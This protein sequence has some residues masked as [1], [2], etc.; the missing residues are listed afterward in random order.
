MTDLTAIVDQ[1]ARD[2]FARQTRSTVAFDDINAAD[3]LAIRSFALPIVT[4]TLDAATP[5]V[6]AQALRDAAYAWQTGQWA[7]APRCR[8]QVQERIA[9]AQHVTEWL[10]ARAAREAGGTP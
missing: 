3:K 8:D 1:V 6:R 2:H 7:D 10:R 5:G 4:A 9:N